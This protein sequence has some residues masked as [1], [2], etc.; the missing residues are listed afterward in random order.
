MDYHLYALFF[1]LLIH[2]P[3]QQQY[4]V[5]DSFHFAEEIFQQDAN[6]LMAG[7]EVDSSFTNIPHIETINI[8]IDN[9][10]NSSKNP[11][12]IPKH[13]FRNLL[14]QSTNHFLCLKTNI[15]TKQMVQLWNL[16]WVQPQL[17]FL[18]A[19]LK[20]TGFKIVLMILSLCSITVMLMTYLH[21]FLLLIMQIDLK[22]ICHLNAPM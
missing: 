7:L 15:I 5:I 2:L 13:D 20:L 4:T 1:C 22:S 3:T 9:L 10:Y 16:N 11:P 17:T 6:L 8:C 19:V 18:S 14:K 21:C 12:N